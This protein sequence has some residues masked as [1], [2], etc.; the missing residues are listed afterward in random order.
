[1]NALRIAVLDYGL[2]NVRSIC[3]ALKAMG[4]DALLTRHAG[5]VMASDGLILPGVG[6]FETGMA[7]IN[8]LNL[9]PLIHDFADAGKPLLGICLGMQMLL[10]FSEENGEH[11]GLDLI[12]GRVAR[13]PVSNGVRLPH[14]GWNRIAPPEG[15]WKSDLFDEAHRNEPVYFVHTYAA[16]PNDPAHILAETEYEGTVFTSAIIRGN[17][18]GTQFH[19]EKSGEAGLRILDHFIHQKSFDYV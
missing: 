12:P 13:L 17:V 2:G 7:N 5:D 15:H 10:S 19:P 18:I 3:N 8:A 6:A 4:A 14:V 1:M 9:A 11:Q 16:K